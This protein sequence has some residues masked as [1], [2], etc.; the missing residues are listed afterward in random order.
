MTHDDVLDGDVL[1]GNVLAGPLAG[2]WA[3][4]VTVATGRCAGCGDVAVLA[5]AVVF[6]HPM[7]R[8]ARCRACG[9]VLMV[10]VERPDGVQVAARGLA[11]VRG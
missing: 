3:L 10:V 8:V 1:D 2:V 7:G 9:Q 5:G 4:D 11:W 6:A